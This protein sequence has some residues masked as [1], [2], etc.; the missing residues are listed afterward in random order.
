MITFYFSCLWNKK[1]GNKEKNDHYR[2]DS[3]II[4]S[5]SA[6]AALIFATSRSTNHFELYISALVK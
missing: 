3:S 2:L 5:S 1:I 6:E 4:V